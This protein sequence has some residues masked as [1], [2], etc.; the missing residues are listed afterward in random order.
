MR[1]TAAQEPLA[2]I[3]R[4]YDAWNVGDVATAAE[5]LA[6]DVRWDTFGAREGDRRD[7]ADARAAARAGRGT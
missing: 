6:P 2:L 4:L 3:R 1:A 5:V 7:A